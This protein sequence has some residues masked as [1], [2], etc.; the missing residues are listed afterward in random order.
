MIM[1]RGFR[2]ISLV[3][4]LAVFMICTCADW[5]AYAQPETV[6]SLSRRMSG[7]FGRGLVNMATGW[8]EMIRCP[9][10]VGRERGP[11]LAF[12][13]GPLKGIAMTVFRTVGGVF[14]T[15]LFF[16]PLP[17]NYAPYF[18]SEFVF[19]KPVPERPPLELP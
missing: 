13:W 5:Y 15:A 1:R 6:R 19:S 7:K 10:E 16:Y 17:E 4:A 12:T 14:E 3:A 8:G 18:E 2:T 11:L 9:I